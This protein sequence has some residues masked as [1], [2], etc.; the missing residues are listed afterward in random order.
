[1]ASF[2]FL[3]ACNKPFTPNTRNRELVMFLQ[4][5]GSEYELIRYPQRGVCLYK[6]GNERYLLEV[7]AGAGGRSRTGY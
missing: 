6:C 3:L 4:L 7:K 5:E 2:T 1:M